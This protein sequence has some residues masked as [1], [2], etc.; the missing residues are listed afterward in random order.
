MMSQSKAL[1]VHLDNN[2]MSVHTEPSLTL[3]CTTKA[4]ST[5]ATGAGANYAIELIGIVPA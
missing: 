1:A 2:F 5:N 4:R 3:A